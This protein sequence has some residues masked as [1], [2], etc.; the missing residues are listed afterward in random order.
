[1]TL[2]PAMAAGA[3]ALSSVSVVANSLRLRA[4][5]VRALTR[6]GS[7]HAR[8]ARVRDAAFLALVALLAVGAAAGVVAADRAI[9]A[10]ATDVT[11][12]ARDNRFTPSEIAVTSGGWVSLTLQNEDAYFHD[13][14][15][16]GLANVDVGAR[17]D[18]TG[19]IRVRLDRPGTYE[20]I[21]TVPGHAEAGMRGTLSV[22]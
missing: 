13:L 18:S 20:F 8:L 19:R 11:V 1:V 9:D 14:E 6:P 21:C 12:V 4:L 17:G 2:N 10:S 16:E 3:M 15:V 5:D 22:R 7:R